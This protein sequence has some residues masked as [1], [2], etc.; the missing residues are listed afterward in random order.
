[1]EEAIRPEATYRPPYQ[2]RRLLM[3]GTTVVAVIVVAALGGW[4]LSRMRQPDGSAPVLRFQI[5]PP[6]GG[7]FGRFA[8]L[9]Y[10]QGLALSPDGRMIVF[11]AI[12]DG[13][14]ALWLRSLDETK[15]HMLIGS[16][17]GLRPFWSPDGRSIAFFS[18]GK[19]RRI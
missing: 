17:N 6:D 18:E 11:G 13:K 10:G 3:F 12:V 4:A 7:K 2:R 14:Y 9:G 1:I 8:P 19:L 15:A 5:N 16:E